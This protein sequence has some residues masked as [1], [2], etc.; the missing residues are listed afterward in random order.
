[1]RYYA[2]IIDPSNDEIDRAS[3]RVSHGTAIGNA[4][5][6]LERKARRE[7]KPLDKGEPHW[8]S[9]CLTWTYS[10]GFIIGGERRTGD[11]IGDY[12]WGG[13]LWLVRADSSMALEHGG[14][15]PLSIDLVEE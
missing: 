8:A 3:S 7:N 6:R 4:I 2:A 10:Q 5:A 11:I 13:E 9:G 14:D 15:N 1:M 12:T